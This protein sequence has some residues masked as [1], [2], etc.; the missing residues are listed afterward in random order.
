MSTV[1][2][3]Q[4][5]HALMTAKE[6]SERLRL[7]PRSIWRMRDAGQMPEPLKLGGSIRWRS[8]E[9]ERWINQGCPKTG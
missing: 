4:K 2:P 5:S 8:D 6:I 7:S 9:I 1:V 3:E